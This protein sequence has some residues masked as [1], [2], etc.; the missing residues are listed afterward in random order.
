MFKLSDLLAYDGIVI[1]C[2]DNP[3]ADAISS[4]FA[5]HTYLSRNGK[6]SKMIYSGIEKIKK[7]NIQL[8]LEWLNITVEHVRDAEEFPKPGLLICVDCQY[9]E[10]NVTRIEADAVAIIDHHLEVA[11]QYDLGVIQSHLGGCATLVWNLLRAEDFDFAANKDVPA[12]LYYGL[13]TDTNDFS[14]INHPLD[15]DMRDSLQVFCDRGIVKRLRMCNLTLEELEIAGVALLR[16]FNNY[17]KRYALFKSEFCD[18]NILGF[19]SDI[20]LQVDTVDVCVVYSQRENG[21]KLSVRSCSR[22]VMAS[23][24]AEYITRGVGSGG[25]HRD[26][27]GGYLQKSEID[28]LGLTVDEYMREK[29]VGYF[30]SYDIIN[31]SDHNI[32]VTHMNRYRKKPIPKGFVISTDVFEENTPLMIRTLEGDSNVK[33]SPDIYLMVGVRGEAYP[34]KSEKFHSYYKLCDEHAVIDLEAGDVYKPTV[35]NRNTG[36]IKELLPLMKSCV[37]FS[38]APIF[39]GVLTRNTKIFTDWNPGGYM[40]GRA[41]DYLAVKCDD[42]NDVYVIQKDIFAQTYEKL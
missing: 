6:A 27:A 41:G 9:G 19:I 4:A 28:D 13:L 17:E 12:A 8:M 20:A 36:E 21:A 23:E 3:D 18:P 1:Q 16:N 32:D 40:Y 24:L 10:G 33:A 22:E 38:E 25:G 31:S 5:I 26:K 35:K 2:H 37:S 11:E 34:I 7:R 42:V 15:K 29:T 30:D 14:E 39:A